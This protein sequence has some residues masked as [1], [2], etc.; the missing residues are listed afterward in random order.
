MKRFM[1]K[2][3]SIILFSIMTIGCLTSCGGAATG[4]AGGGG[5]KKILLAL[6]DETSST[7]EALLAAMSA[8]ATKQGASIDVVY[9]EKNADKQAAQIAEAAGKYDAIICRISDASTALQM[10]VAAGG[11]PIIFINNAPENDV[12][13]PDKYMFVGSYEYDAGRF[14]AEYIWNGLGKP[15]SVNAIIIKGQKGHSSVPGRTDSIKYFFKDNNVNAN[16]VFEDFG[17]WSDTGA[18]EKLDAFKLTGQQVD[19]IFCNSDKMALGAISWLK[20]NG[21]DPSKVLVAGIDASSAGCEAVIANEMYVTVLQDLDAQ[22]TTAMQTAVALASGKSV[23]NF[24][25]ISSDQKHIYIPFVP[26]DKTNV[27]QYK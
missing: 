24:E 2:I 16:Y 9:C 26:V 22:G 4:S 17:N 5:S 10:E 8:E 14:Q 6:H 11:I 7:I 15:S 12:L 13:K 27:N 3:I 20:D 21:Y 1:K 19:C 23:T 18:Y 25:G